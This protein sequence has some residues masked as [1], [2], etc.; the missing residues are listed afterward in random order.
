MKTLANTLTPVA[1]LS[2]LC[3]LHLMASCGAAEKFPGIAPEEDPTAILHNPDM[4]WV[5]YENYPID[6]EPAGSST[7]LTVPDEPFEGV[8]QVALMFSWA[9]VEKEENLYDFSKPNYAYD[10]W[11]GRG[12]EIQLRVSSESLLWWANREPPS[13]QG[14]P[15]YL[16]KQI[17]PEQKQVRENSGIHYDVVDSRNPAY[18]ER[19]SKFLT[20]LDANFAR[21]PVTLIDLR[22]FGLWG[23]W[24]S[25]FQYSSPKDRHAALSTI[26][27]VWSQAL[28]G[29]FLSLSYSYDPDGPK[30]YY[31]GPRDRLDLPSTTHYGE[32]LAY[33]AFEHA[34]SKSNITF[35]RDG[36]G[37]ALGSNERLLCENAFATFHKG[38]FMSE[39]LGGYAQNKKGGDKWV[40]SMVDDALSL[41]PNYIA[42]LGWQ[43]G[44][45]RDFLR[46]E[47]EL[48]SKGSREMGYRLVPVKVSCPNRLAP[49]QLFTITTEWINRGVGRAQ[50]NFELL[51]SLRDKTDAAVFR[52]DAGPIPSSQWVKGAT[53]STTH[54]LTFENLT[55]GDYWLAVRVVD[56][57][58]R[59][60]IELPLKHKLADGSYTLGIVTVSD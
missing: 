46:N 54:T 10:Y 59:R 28:P 38:P 19:L 5:V 49:A 24:H 23:E 8:D 30:E 55:P 41:H 26:L 51:V 56:P 25:G 27:D 32:Y 22:G 43:G 31:E 2:L 48:V 44:D 40:R 42:L 11:R 20:A 18:Q 9:D 52:A 17:P 57:A 47:P 60:T 45:A 3:L 21:R 14:V 15:D 4:G 36:C 6:Q 39:F 1:G 13:G 12:K 35:R 34:L 33:S 53:Y 29:H 50:R 16:L 58:T 7:L 37:G